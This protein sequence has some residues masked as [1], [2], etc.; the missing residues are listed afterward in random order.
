MPARIW[1]NEMEL[2][3]THATM[4]SNCGFSSY[5]LQV[6]LFLDVLCP[7]SS[8]ATVSKVNRIRLNSTGL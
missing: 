3:L 4:P 2:I 1:H 7:P 6:Q 5:H 8:D